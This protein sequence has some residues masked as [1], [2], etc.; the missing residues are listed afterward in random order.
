MLRGLGKLE[1]HGNSDCS[2]LSEL[3]RS[4]VKVSIRILE[5][6]EVVHHCVYLRA[7]VRSADALQ[8][9]PLRIPIAYNKDL[10]ALL[11]LL[12]VAL[13][14][15][16]LLLLYSPTYCSYSALNGPPS[17][18]KSI[19]TATISSCLFL[20]DYTTLT[21][22]SLAVDSHIHSGCLINISEQINY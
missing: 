10:K 3:F 5:A 21:V 12:S 14:I 19:G 16:Q 4:Y 15:F 2:P 13:S 18:P 8:L 22:L 20:Q 7:A 1:L 17:E 11:H 9:L 6:R